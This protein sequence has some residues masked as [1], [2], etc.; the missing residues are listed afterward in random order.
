MLK[1][2]IKLD[3]T[4]GCPRHDTSEVENLG[5]DNSANVCGKKNNKEFQERL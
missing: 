4:A 3:I 5:F 2:T 1:Q